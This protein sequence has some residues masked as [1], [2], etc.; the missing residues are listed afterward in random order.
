MKKS[1]YYLCFLLLFTITNLQA[2]HF[3]FP[4]GNPE[5]PFYTMY[6]AGASL[7]N[8]NLSQNDEIAVFDGE[9]MVGVFSLTQECT[10]E[11]AFA[12]VLIAW[13]LLNN[14]NQGYIPGNNV[15][16][17]CWKA[18]DELEVVDFEII[19]TDPYGGAWTE[20]TFPEGENKYSIPIIN[21]FT[22]KGSIEGIISDTITGQP[23]T[24][25]SISIENKP[26]STTTNLQGEYF[27][28]E[29]PIGE[30]NLNIEANGYFSKTK[31]NI[32][33]LPNETTIC[34]IELHILTPVLIET[35][36]GNEEITIV[37][38]SIQQNSSDG[39]FNFEGGNSNFPSWTIYLSSAFID[40]VDLEA[41]DEIGIFDGDIL[42]GAFTLTEV[43]T[44]ENFLSNPLIAYSEL[45]SGQGYTPGNPIFLKCWDNSE[46]QEFSKFDISFSD[47]YGGAWMEAFFPTDANNY[48]IVEIDFASFFFNIYYGNGDLVAENVG[49]P[50]FTDT[51]LDPEIEYCYYVKQILINGEESLPSNVLCNIPLPPLA[52][53]IT[54]AIPGI[55]EITIY[56]EPL[57][58]IFNLYYEDG[59][60]IAEN[61]ED[62]FY[63]DT[64]LIVGQEYCYFVTQILE[65]GEESPP[66]NIYCSQPLSPPSPYLIKAQAGFEMVTLTWN[67]V[68]FENPSGDHFEFQGGDTTNNHWIIFISGAY[69]D[70]IS[71]RPNDEIAIFD[72]DS[73][74]GVYHLQRVCT[75]E[76]MFENDLYAFSVLTGGETGY[77]PGDSLKFKCWKNGG[78]TGIE[79][80]DFEYSF[81]DPFG[82]AWMGEIFPEGTGKYSCIELNFTSYY[83]NVYYDDG[84]I[85][86]ENLTEME[87]VDSNLIPLQEYCYYVTQILPDLSE[88]IPSNTKC[89]TPMMQPHFIFY[90]G[91]FI[92][93]IWTMYIS[94]VTL[95]GVDLEAGDALAITNNDTIV[96]VFNLDQVC[97]PENMFENDFIIWKTIFLEDFTMVPGYT[98]G[99][100]YYIKCW[101]EDEQIEASC[102]E[103]VFTN[104][105][106]DAYCGDVFPDGDAQYSLV[107][108]HFQTPSSQSIQ[109]N[110]DYQLS[111]SNISPIEENMLSVLNNN[112]NE[113][114]NFVKD[115]SNYSVQKVG[116]FWINNIGNWKNSDAYLFNMFEDDHLSIEGCEICADTPIPLNI[117]YQLCSYFPQ[118]TLNSLEGFSS[119]LSDSLDFIRN[120]EGKVLRKVG[121][122]WVNGFSGCSPGEGFLISMFDID[123]LVYPDAMR[124]VMPTKNSLETVYFEN[125]FGNAL[126]PVWTIYF[127]LPETVDPGDEIALFDEEKLVGSFMITSFNEFD[128]DLTAW[129]T[130]NSGAGYEAGN[131]LI[132]KLW[133]NSEAME[134]IIDVVFVN[135]YGDAYVNDFFPETDGEYS[136]AEFDYVGI[137]EDLNLTGNFLGDNFPN[138][139]TKSTR[140]DFGLKSSGY[141]SLTLLNTFGEVISIL[142]NRDFE[143]G[144]HSFE[145]NNNDLTP[146]I[147]Y[148]KI[149][150]ESFG[151]TFVETRRIVVI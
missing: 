79:S 17:K 91:Y 42:V 89:A 123:T 46:G 119:I 22:P 19:Y 111:S 8:I 118:N 124:K 86:A 127:E 96:G 40:E 147:Y 84:S 9:T 121:Q 11:N 138:P 78:E 4:G 24:N 83:F 142:I 56:W 72:N 47:P 112:L 73:L 60:L 85:V 94:S 87:Y 58:G 95:N 67:P 36:Q 136:I 27:L 14:G 53:I 103:V 52:P 70:G 80:V 48:S 110:P 93:F 6:F 132:F 77:I 106:G 25:A 71:L 115:V 137:H 35:I 49:G 92:D 120:S 108:L 101:D 99:N 146:G 113:N 133:D 33:V 149:V 15:I 57:E 1:I 12:N 23:I 26:Y 44:P 97:T 143:K 21:F 43:L 74:V 131:S 39:H 65:G 104:P 109:L 5:A 7:N 100:K 98:I 134:S 30:Y 116:P 145:F 55:E 125:V 63:T 107:E 68:L 135:P 61:I 105:Y 64:A 34:D 10:P 37:W 59:T 76:N 41:N 139:F 31:K 16:F 62:S 66:S 114:L 38:E 148:Y 2:Q 128:N 140:I 51:G 129:T 32:I 20:N 122:E 130:L 141:V 75:P 81:F 54:D 150:I 90:G 88:S 13:Q 102:F 28:N 144:K 45:V 117:G 126:N 18:D 50:S 151:K 82:D 29:I 3:E 69:L